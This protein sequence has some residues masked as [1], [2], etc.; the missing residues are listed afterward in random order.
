MQPRFC[1]AA[2]QHCSAI[3][4]SAL[5]CPTRP[6]VAILRQ[7]ALLHHTIVSCNTAYATNAVPL[8][9]TNVTMLW[10]PPLPARAQTG[11]LARACVRRLACRCCCARAS[12]AACARA[13]HCPASS[14]PASF[15]QFRHHFQFRSVRFTHLNLV[16]KFCAA[17]DRWPLLGRHTT[18]A[19]R[20]PRTHAHPPICL[21]LPPGRVSSD[22]DTR[23]R[24]L[25]ART[26]ALFVPNSTA[27][28]A[29]IAVEAYERA[30]AGLPVG[31][32]VLP[33]QTSPSPLPAVDAVVDAARSPHPH[34]QQAARVA[35][36]AAASALWS[37]AGVE[38]HTS[39]VGC[40]TYARAVTL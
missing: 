14:A 8:Q 18:R 10:A 2:T 40:L 19:L 15:K 3:L 28:R 35:R 39:S 9:H 7:T 24:A 1:N 22:G 26:R 33:R 4:Y 31:P 29:D 13:I 36:C 37:P 6:D 32:R 5:Q 25:R 34:T 16:G 27:A 21:S 17:C 30:R 11:P 23:L 38:V 20:R 12:V